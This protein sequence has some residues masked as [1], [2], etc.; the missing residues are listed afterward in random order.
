MVRKKT[1]KSR[2]SC[3]DTERKVEEMDRKA[4]NKKKLKGNHTQIKPVILIP[5]SL[6]KY[7][8]KKGNK[9]IVTEFTWGKINFRGQCYGLNVHVP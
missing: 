3:V 6:K 4:K 2:K 5:K 8:A 1:A 9:I 7:N